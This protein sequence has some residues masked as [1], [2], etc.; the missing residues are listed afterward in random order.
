MMLLDLRLGCSSFDKAGMVRCPQRRSLRG[1]LNGDTLGAG[2]A[3]G[4]QG[5]TGGK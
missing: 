3:I 1:G 4:G 2:E 5:G